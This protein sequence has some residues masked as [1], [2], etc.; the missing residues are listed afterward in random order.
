MKALL[1]IEIPYRLSGKDTEQLKA[2]WDEFK[3]DMS[4]PLFLD[5]GATA[6]VLYL[7]DDSELGIFT[8]EEFEQ[9]TALIN[10]ATGKSTVAPAPD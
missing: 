6:K 8:P 2:Y 9:L 5:G 1:V 7:P 10:R 4:R 3:K